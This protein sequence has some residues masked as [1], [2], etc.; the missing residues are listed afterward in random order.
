MVSIPIVPHN[1]RMEFT[2]EQI[3][4]AAGILVAVLIAIV[5]LIRRLRRPKRDP[6]AGQ[7]DLSIDLSQVQLTPADPDGPSLHVYGTPV[8]LAVIVVASA[9][10]GNPIPG[11]DRVPELLDQIVPGFQ[12]M[13]EKHQPMIR[14]WPTQLSVQ[15]FSHS[16]FNLVSLPGERGKGSPWCSVAGRIP[17]QNHPVLV[18]LAARAENANSLGQINIQHEGQWLDVLRIQR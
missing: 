4:I 14:V 15:G 16:F 17:S 6:Q 1:T 12:E 13:L 5:I 10:R 8:Q 11:L 18:G 3:A 7:I 9:G 2:V